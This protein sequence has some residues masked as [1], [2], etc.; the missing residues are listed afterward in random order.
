[1]YATLNGGYGYDV[2]RNE[3][4]YAVLN[5]GEGNDSLIGNDGAIET[6]YYGEGDDTI[7][8][9]GREDTIRLG[10]EYTNAT[11]SGR[12][13]VI[14]TAAGKLTVRNAAKMAINIRNVSNRTEIL[15]EENDELATLAGSET[16]ERSLPDGAFYDL[17]RRTITINSAYISQLAASNYAASVTDIDASKMKT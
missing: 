11:V 15:N 8:N 16:V 3:G 5:G 2:V 9:Y 4:D 1:M 10:I 6:F 12:D 14:S 7:L 17:E 13:F